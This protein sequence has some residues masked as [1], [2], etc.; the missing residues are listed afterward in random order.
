MEC[1]HHNILPLCKALHGRP[2]PWPSKPQKLWPFYQERKR[3]L[4]RRNPRKVRCGKVELV[5]LGFFPPEPFGIIIVS[6][7]IYSGQE[8]DNEWERKKNKARVRRWFFPHMCFHLLAKTN[9]TKWRISVGI[10]RLKSQNNLWPKRWIFLQSNPSPK[11]DRPP[12]PKKCVENWRSQPKTAP[13]KQRK[14][15]WN[16]CLSRMDVWQGGCG[17]VG[18]Y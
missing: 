14:R 3:F 1:H 12:P 5:N 15:C 10:L 17:G 4:K 7:Y 11:K 8:K 18:W 6:E 16:V 9:F 13:R 2:K